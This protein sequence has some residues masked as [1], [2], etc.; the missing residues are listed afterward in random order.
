MIASM[1]QAAP[2][3]AQEAG[4][5][6]LTSAVRQAVNG[7]P[8]VQAAWHAFQAS[9]DEVDVARGEYLPSVDLTAA[10]GRE[11]VDDDGADSYSTDYVELSLTQMLYD[12]FSTRNEVARLDRAR[13]VRFLEL[14]DTS[15]KVAF[16]TFRAY[17]DVRR[18]RELVAL[19]RDN[20]AKHL[21]VYRQIEE[22]VASG[23]GRRVDLEQIS[24][25]LSL[26]ESNLM[27][28]AANLHD[29]SARFQR[30]VGRVPALSLAPTPALSERL[31]A[32]LQTTL[33]EAYR[34]NPGFHAA[35]ENIEA[36]RKELAGTRS[37]FQP[38]LELQAQTGRNNWSSGSARRDGHTAELVASVNLYRGGSDLARFR[39][40]SDEVERSL[41]LR[42]QECVSLRQTTSIAYQSA[43]RL[44]E[45][46]RYLNQHR[47]H[48]DRVRGAYQQQFDIGQRTLLDVLDSEN[49]YFDASRAYANALHDQRI[50]Q[51]ETLS[52]MGALLAELEVRRD[53]LPSLG[54]LGGQ[55]AV[56]D[57][58]AI[59]PAQGP[60]RLTLDDLTTGLDVPKAA[61]PDI[62]LSAD[63]LF[64]P[65]SAELS[66]RARDELSGL[67]AELKARN[68]LVGIVIAGHADST[69]SDAVNEPLSQD[70]ADRV[71]GYLATRGVSRDLLEAR[72]FGSRR[73]MTT[74]A[75]AE[76]RRANRRVEITL[77]TREV[78]FHASPGRPGSLSAAYAA[79]SDAAPAAPAAP[80]A[81]DVAYIQIVALSAADRAMALKEDLT[82]RLGGELRVL[83]GERLHRVQ[84]GPIAKQEVPVLQAELESLG[85]TD[86]FVVA[87]DQ[88]G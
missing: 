47:Q 11:D 7:N 84:V 56:T 36:T 45:Q 72:G 86:S 8:E 21:R 49:E 4:T 28:E 75:T 18:Y 3:L 64:A 14:L 2:G 87:T 54:E 27:T 39:Q 65:G 46:Q 79:V 9:A 40:V 19:A 62:V 83:S 32:S 50:A 81:T 74:N 71:A 51:A 57:P 52:A 60:A 55:G 16:E 24:G 69:G 70:R 29:V 43:Q 44:E 34:G 5:A 30:L 17:E 12:G 22:R 6:T 58:G 59:C 82:T 26:A 13:R 15:E 66:P 78:G 35:I 67:A 31:P 41:S 68:D 10:V 53:G 76:G 37:A 23:A 73:P 80:V 88:P 33:N 61:S 1:M 77:E 63:A 48:I 85:Y 42:D 38:R 25:R 20:Y